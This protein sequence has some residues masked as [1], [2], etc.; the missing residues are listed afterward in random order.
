MA[1]IALEDLQP[2]VIRFLLD[3]WGLKMEILDH[4]PENPFNDT[5]IIRV[6]SGRCQVDQQVLMNCVV[7]P[8]NLDMFMKSAILSAIRGVFEAPY[9][10]KLDEL[11]TELAECHAELQRVDEELRDYKHI[12]HN[13][14]IC[15]VCGR[16]MKR[17]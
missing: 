4:D 15:S 9:K 8:E 13:G 17:K 7:Y 5:K 14:P 6:T 12:V 11:K 2:D 10:L 3:Y 1:E 16:N